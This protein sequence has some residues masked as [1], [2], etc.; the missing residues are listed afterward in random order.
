MLVDQD[1]Q[2]K[3]L[4]DQKHSGRSEGRF[5]GCPHRVLKYLVAE[6]MIRSMSYYDKRQ[7]NYN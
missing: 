1:I 3:V 4:I 5:V 2:A 7:R 6:Y